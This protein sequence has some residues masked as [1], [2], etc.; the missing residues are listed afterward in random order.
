MGEGH[1]EARICAV[2]LGRHDCAGA[3]GHVGL[4]LRGHRRL[5]DAVIVGRED[6]AILEQ[7]EGASA[8]N[9]HPASCLLLFVEDVVDCL[10]HEGKPIDSGIAWIGQRRAPQQVDDEPIDAALKNVE[11]D[12]VRIRAVD[13]EAAAAV[14]IEHGGVASIFRPAQH[15]DEG[16]GAVVQLYLDDGDVPR[17]SQ[18]T[19]N[20]IVTVI[21]AESLED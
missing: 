11:R 19:P 7:A 12:R 1:G 21:P 13:Q 20:A 5:G 6:D 3:G 16:V 17:N 14:L 18:L 10:H 15:L 9:G 2:D 4:P 8:G